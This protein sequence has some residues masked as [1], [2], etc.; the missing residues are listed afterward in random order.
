MHAA[1]RI[2]S[3]FVSVHCHPTSLQLLLEEE[4]MM[5]AVS[6]WLPEEGTSDAASLRLCVCQLRTL[7]L[8]KA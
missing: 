2:L 3:C 8:N 7:H 1:P 5:T 6:P 4:V